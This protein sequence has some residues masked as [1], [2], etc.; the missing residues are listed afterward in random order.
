MTRT[1]EDVAMSGGGGE[2]EPLE[3]KLLKPY[4]NR[5][6]GGNRLGRLLWGVVWLVLFRPTPRFMLGWRRFLLRCF[7]AKMGRGSNVH[8]SVKIWAPWNLEMADH[9]CLAFG[10]DCYC[11]DKVRLGVRATVSQYSFLCTA[12]HDVY[13]A[14]TP[15]VTAPITVEDGAWVFAGAFVGPGVTVG[16]GAVVAARAVVVKRVEP[17]TIVAGNPA[18]MIKKRVLREGGR[19]ERA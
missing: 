13:D 14:D 11:V 7:G 17:W 8:A 3:E 1:G 16:K 19:G 12:G 6:S 4:A 9:S 2:D 5:L 15:L 10:V 18:Q